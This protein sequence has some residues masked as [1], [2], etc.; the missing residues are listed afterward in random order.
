MVVKDR[1]PL[2]MLSQGCSVIHRVHG[3]RS[4]MDGHDNRRETARDRNNIAFS[5]LCTPACDTG[6]GFPESGLKILRTL[7][8]AVGSEQ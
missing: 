4:V 3:C 8:T 7:D 1:C 5:S 2:Y 6:N